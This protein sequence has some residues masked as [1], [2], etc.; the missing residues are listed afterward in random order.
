MELLFQLDYF[1][2]VL[3][4]TLTSLLNSV[5]YS[6]QQKKKMCYVYH[7]MLNRQEMDHGS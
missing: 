2:W 4:L 3:R 5:L 7:T 6:T 1:S